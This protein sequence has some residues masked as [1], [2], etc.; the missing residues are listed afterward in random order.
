VLRDAVRYWFLRDDHV[1]FMLQV[2]PTRPERRGQIATV[3]HFDGTGRPQTVD[4][5]RIPAIMP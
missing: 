4:R 3:T 2:I 5:A 1:P